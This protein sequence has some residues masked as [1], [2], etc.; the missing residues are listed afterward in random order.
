LLAHRLVLDQRSVF[1][2]KTCMVPL[3]DVSDHS[4]FCQV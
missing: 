4:Q 3:G 2:E 1:L